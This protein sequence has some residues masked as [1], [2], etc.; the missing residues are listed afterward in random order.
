MRKPRFIIA[1]VVILL[2]VSVLTALAVNAVKNNPAGS[3]TAVQTAAEPE[4]FP[5]E[6][7]SY[8]EY[9]F[10][11][12]EASGSGI[13]T[14]D[15]K[16][17]ME[18]ISKSKHRNYYLVEMKGDPIRY[19]PEG[20]FGL[21][22]GIDSQKVYYLSD[23]QWDKLISAKNLQPESIPDFGSILFE[24]PL[25]HG[26]IYGAIDPGR[27]DNMYAYYVERD[28]NYN[29]CVTGK[30]GK[31]LASYRISFTCTPDVTTC[32]FVPHLGI[33]GTSYHHNGTVIDY[34]VKLIKYELH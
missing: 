22:I 13:V 29:G 15:Q 2:L 26:Q 21:A 3:S 18:V 34:S 9:S 5:L 30:P 16:I 1:I 8:W 11:S 20:R 32:T 17:H 14:K 24:F 6:P 7:G 27:S 28:G 10:N 25:S 33:T 19:S 31:P 4:Y 12:R 23:T